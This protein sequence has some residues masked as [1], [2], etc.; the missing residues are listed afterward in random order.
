MSKEQLAEIET[1]FHSDDHFLWWHSND[2]LDAEDE[3][4]EDYCRQSL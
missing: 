2:D 1:L 3:D 4:I